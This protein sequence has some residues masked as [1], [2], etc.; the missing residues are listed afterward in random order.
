MK[1]ILPAPKQNRK[2]VI[3]RMKTVLNFDQ[4]SA[5]SGLDLNDKFLKAFAGFWQ[6]LGSMS[7]LHA[8]CSKKI[9]QHVQV[10]NSTIS[11]HFRKIFHLS[12]TANIGGLLEGFMEEM[13]ELVDFQV[14]LVEKNPRLGRKI[15]HQKKFQNELLV[16]VS[17]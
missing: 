9:R 4:H 14:G 7:D 3:E 10:M 15:G 13:S 11:R 12:N 1:D 5:Q 17:K 6:I 8:N 2:M 16:F